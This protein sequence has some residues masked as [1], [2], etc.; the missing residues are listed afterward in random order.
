MAHTQLS[1]QG[2]TDT[3]ELSLNWFTRKV[4]TFQSCTTAQSAFLCFTQGV[5][6]GQVNNP[7]TDWKNHLESRCIQFI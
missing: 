1:H 4:N 5:A 3:E 7:D 2:M 6:Q